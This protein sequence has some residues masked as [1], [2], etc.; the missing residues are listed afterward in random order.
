MVGTNG[1]DPTDVVIAP[2][3]SMF[4]SMGGRGTGGAVYHIEYVG[5]G[6]T[7]VTREKSPD[8]DLDA[9]LAVREPLEAWSCAKWM[10]LAKKRREPIRRGGD[11]GATVR[12]GSHVRVEILT[13][14]FGGLPPAT[15]KEGAKQRPR[16]FVRVA[17]SLGLSAPC[18]GFIDI[19]R[20][21][22]TDK[23]ARC[24]VSRWHPLQIMPKT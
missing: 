15:A 6:K 22:A 24:V 18:T 16:R 7:P 12:H 11:V 20:G 3:G 2:D 5:D 21:L 13:E 23:D 19:L 14:L 1:F 10:P 4:I 17:W 9:V 8:N